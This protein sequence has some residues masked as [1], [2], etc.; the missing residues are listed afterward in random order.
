MTGRQLQNIQ[1]V[2]AKTRTIQLNVNPQVIV[3]V[4]EDV[5]GKVQ[6]KKVILK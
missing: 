5:N 6:T 2:N 3:V 1:Q 4:V